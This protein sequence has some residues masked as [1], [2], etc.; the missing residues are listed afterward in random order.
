M[1]RMM[2]I[3]VGDWSDDHG[4]QYETIIVKMSGDDVSDEVLQ[5]NY[6]ETVKM[7]GVDIMEVT[8]EPGWYKA[9]TELIESLDFGDFSTS[10]DGDD[11]N[12]FDIGVTTNT[13]GGDE[14]VVT[15]C[16]LLMWYVGRGIGN[17]SWAYENIDTL[18]GGYTTTLTP[19]DR[20]SRG[21]SSS[22]GRTFR[23][24]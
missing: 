18:V 20:R 8:C 6:G 3:N 23:D 9:L 11:Y 5:A 2:K 16:G 13:S 24:Y 4:G 21:R 22:I 19:L 12:D 10:G 1:E 14:R 17:F 15:I 7:T